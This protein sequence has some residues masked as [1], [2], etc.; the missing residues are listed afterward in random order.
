MGLETPPNLQHSMGH[1]RMPK[2][3][4]RSGAAFGSPS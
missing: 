3:A 4:E 1:S 2:V